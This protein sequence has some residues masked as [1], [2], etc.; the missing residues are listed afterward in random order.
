MAMILMKTT[1]RLRVMMRGKCE[2][3]WAPEEEAA[4]GSS[5]QRYP[6]EGAALQYLM[7]EETVQCA[8]YTWQCDIKHYFS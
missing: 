3:N 5:F 8:S 6:L 4:P 7:Q 2:M 1:M